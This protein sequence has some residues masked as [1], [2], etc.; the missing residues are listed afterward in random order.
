MRR[1][2]DIPVEISPVAF[3]EVIW[4]DELAQTRADF[5]VG[6]DEDLADGDGVEPAFDPAPDCGEERGGT[7]D[8]DIIR[9]THNKKKM[10]LT[11]IRSSV[12]G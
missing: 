3:G 1:L 8:L 7:E 4:V 5:R 9:G 2:S 6:E 11:N 12:S 10:G